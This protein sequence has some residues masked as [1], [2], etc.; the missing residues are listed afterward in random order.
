MITLNV[1]FN[2]KE[3]C[4]EDFLALLDNMVTESNKEE[5][6]SYY[7]L[8]ADLTA[9]NWYSLIELWDSQEALN[10]HNKTAHW[11]KFN[12]I[13]NDYLVTPY[14]EHHYTEVPF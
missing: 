2:V 4:K 1:F 9:T 5:G 8:M 6:C 10:L 13:V 11:I 3:D 14:D 12:D 7:H